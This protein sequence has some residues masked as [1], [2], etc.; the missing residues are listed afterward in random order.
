MKERGVYFVIM[1]IGMCVVL[2]LAG[3]GI[4]GAKLFHERL[5]L[6]KAADA[7]VVAGLA[8][9][10]QVG[11]PDLNAFLIGTSPNQVPC[12]SVLCKAAEM[13]RANLT[14]ANLS[15]AAATVEA[16]SV[17]AHNANPES[18]TLVLR[19]RVDFY[20]IDLIPF[21]LFGVSGI[22]GADLIVT[23]EGRL[24]PARVALMLDFSG[25]MCCRDNTAGNCL[26][27]GAGGCGTAAANNR[28]V[29]RLREATHAFLDKFRDGRDNL[30]IVPFNITAKVT[31]KLNAT[32]NRTQWKTEITNLAVAPASDTNPSDALIE[33]YR[34]FR[35]SGFRGTSDMNYVLFSDGAPTAARL[36]A[37]A[38]SV[39]AGANFPAWDPH[40]LCAAGAACRDYY[41]Y[42]LEW[43]CS[44]VSSPHCPNVGDYY[45]GP[46]PLLQSAEAN[47]P[48]TNYA[49]WFLPY[50][51][52]SGEPKYYNGITTPGMP[53]CTGLRSG[54]NRWS[55]L[56]GCLNSFQLVVPY[57]GTLYGSNVLLNNSNWS[58]QYYNA[59][60]MMAD[61][62]RAGTAAAPERGTFYVIGLGT[63]ASA[64]AMGAAPDPYQDANSDYAR[65]DYFLNRLALDKDICQ[66]SSSICSPGGSARTCCTAGGAR[67]QQ[68]FPIIGASTWATYGVDAANY[69]HAGG[70]A[71]RYQNRYRFGEYLPTHDA[72]ELRALFE[73]VAK[74]ILLRLIR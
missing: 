32:F 43:Q 35:A 67:Y 36:L 63:P 14:Y 9:R 17:Y 30:S 38:S 24:S 71:V 64:L 59:A 46:S 15:G 44:A 74:K 2:A 62:M 25:S 72:N 39:A 10:I 34:D 20:L 45:L 23:A 18:L 4:D 28:K 12:V 19:K 7:G 3:L 27:P 57:S 26:R 73:R 31:K 53:A 29:D 40:G 54:A 22:D 65:K 51:W 5:L 49:N 42:K 16:A 52:A 8:Y 69:G 13:A 66:L 33:A 68:D 6:Q 48:Y 1:S 58:Q 41:N 47:S 56:T 21:G 50:D 11:P 70:A 61:L 37:P 60:L 55:A